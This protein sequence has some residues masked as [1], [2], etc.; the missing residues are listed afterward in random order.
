MVVLKSPLVRI[1]TCTLT[2][3]LMLK[4]MP[5]FLLMES[6]WH[7]HGKMECWQE[8]QDWVWKFYSQACGGGKFSE[9]S[10]Q[11]CHC[12]LSNIPLGPWLF[13]ENCRSSSSIFDTLAFLE[14]RQLDAL[15]ELA[16]LALLS[17]S[18]CSQSHA[19][20]FQQI[21]KLILAALLELC[22]MT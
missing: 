9:A 16:R 7:C 19:W 10:D 12:W 14:L 18:D 2:L 11:L 3:P 13:K 22:L 17:P 4:F 15:L 5:L 1:I 21:S 6:E 8:S 20:H